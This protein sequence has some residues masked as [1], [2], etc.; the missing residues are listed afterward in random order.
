M[1]K[2]EA[3]AMSS[4]ELVDSDFDTDGREG[5]VAN[6]LLPIITLV[7]ATI[8]MM[9]YTGNASLAADGKEFT[10]LGAFENTSVGISLVVGAL[11]SLGIATVLILGSRH[12]TFQE[13]LVAYYLGIKSMIGAILV[14]F[15]AWTINSVVGDIQTGKFLSTLITGNL[16]H[17]LLPAV[18]FVLA[19]V[20]AF[21]TGT[22]WGTFGIML[23]I[24]AAIAADVDPM[25]F[26]PCLSAVMAGAVCGDHCSPISD[27][28]ILSSTG[29]K[30]EHIE[31][32]RTQLPYALIVALASVSGYLV[33]GYT[34]SPLFGFITAS[35]VLA[36]IVLIFRARQSNDLNVTKSTIA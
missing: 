26:L 16:A 7:F 30:C 3:I 4:D 11:A 22:S 36:V 34:K 20:M 32:V 33:V 2:S 21:S 1:A 18:L 35:V 5:H 23:P 19:A 15:F 17:E 8:G 25:L 31:H 27:T 14:L 12:A 13:Y 10:I 29:A 9:M 6:L 28:T 24:G